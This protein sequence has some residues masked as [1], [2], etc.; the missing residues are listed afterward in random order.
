MSS[1][2]L[3]KALLDWNFTG[4]WRGLT[5]FP[6]IDGDQVGNS[7]DQ[8]VVEVREEVVPDDQRLADREKN[9]NFSQ[10]KFKRKKGPISAQIT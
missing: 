7:S 2:A 4:K 8:Q 5:E 9:T 3:N 1:V 10:A 6:I